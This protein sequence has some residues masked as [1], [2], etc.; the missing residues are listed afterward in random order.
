MTYNS[1]QIEGIT[2]IFLWSLVSPKLFYYWS[3]RE[4]QKQT[5]YTAHLLPKMLGKK[6]NNSHTVLS[7]EAWSPRQNKPGKYGN[8][9]AVGTTNNS[10]YRSLN[11]LS[12]Q[13]GHIQQSRFKRTVHL[14]QVHESSSWDNGR[15]QFVSPLC[16]QDNLQCL[17]INNFNPQFSLAQ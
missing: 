14:V 6:I 11:D 3:Q 15:A 2:D 12:D 13:L 4:L 7:L 1:C 8:R 5:S 10:L 9:Y 16:A 17:Q